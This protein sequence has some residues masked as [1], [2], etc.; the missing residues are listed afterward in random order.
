M[1]QTYCDIK[2]NI[3]RYANYLGRAQNLLANVSK[4]LAINA[5][6]HQHLCFIYVF[7]CVGRYYATI[8]EQA[9]MLLVRADLVTNLFENGWGYHCSVLVRL[10][11]IYAKLN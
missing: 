5:L 8:R 2:L 4:L 11:A 3:G 1:R 7:A 10:L 6:L 9:K